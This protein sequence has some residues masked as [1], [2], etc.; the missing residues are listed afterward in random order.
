MP[1]GTTSPDWSSGPT[2]TRCLG[3]NPLR[4]GPPRSEE[5]SGGF[6]TPHRGPAPS[7]RCGSPRGAVSD[8]SLRA[9]N[10]GDG[11]T[12]DP[13]TVT[14][15]GGV[16]GAPGNRTRCEPAPLTRRGNSS[17]GGGTSPHR[18]ATVVSPA[19]HSEHAAKVVSLTTHCAVVKGQE[20]CH[21][22]RHRRWDPGTL[23]RTPE[24]GRP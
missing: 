6:F 4:S 17:A 20:R 15:T 3:P 10:T 11:R 9:R 21:E 18:T 7:G 22:Q 2:P 19:P 16:W 1:T 5:R 12:R 13:P 14:V 24:P 8:L 23:G